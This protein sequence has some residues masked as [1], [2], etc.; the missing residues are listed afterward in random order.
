MLRPENMAEGAPESGSKISTTPLGVPE[1]AQEVA[2]ATWGGENPLKSLTGQLGGS[3]GGLTPDQQERLREVQERGRFS[4]SG[5]PVATEAGGLPGGGGRPPVAEG[6][7]EPESH[8]EWL[9]SP[10]RGR[11]LVEEFLRYRLTMS[12]EVRY[13]T[14]NGPRF[15]WICDEI[16]KYVDGISETRND[17]DEFGPYQAFPRPPERKLIINEAG[18]KVLE[19][20]RPPEFLPK[21]QELER[22]DK[23][24]EELH[25]QY[26]LEGA[27]QLEQPTETH[28]RDEALATENGK[29][30]FA[31]SFWDRYTKIDRI[32]SDDESENYPKTPDELDALL[33]EASTAIKQVDVYVRQ[34][35]N[36]GLLEEVEVVLNSLYQRI[37]QPGISL[38]HVRAYLRDGKV[39]AIDAA[40]AEFKEKSLENHNLAVF[41]GIGK[42][43]VELAL[44]T[45]ERSVRGM[46]QP[47]KERGE[48][49]WLTPSAEQA[50]KGKKETYWTTGSWPKYYQVTAETEEQFLVAKDTFFQMIRTA[51]LGKS[52]DAV[53][54]HVQNFIEAFKGAG[55]R[56]V[57]ERNISNEFLLEN[58]LELEALLFV[59]V[60]NYS[61]E[62]YNHKQRYDAMMA[63]SKDEGP[64]R[65]VGIY[66]SGKGGAAS[67]GEIFDMEA[68]MDIY[69]NPVGE[70]GELTITSGHFLQ[71]MIQEIVIERGMGIAL[72][73]Y[74]P[75]EPYLNSDDLKA[76]IYAAKELERINSDLQEY[77]RGIRD[78]NL[79]LDAG[80]Q[81]VKL[82]QGVIELKNGRV[83][84][85]RGCTAEWLLSDRDQTRL[86][87]F[88]S[89]LK[90][91]GLTKSHEEFRALYEGFDKGDTH[92]KNYRS[93][94]KAQKEDKDKPK[95]Q[96][97]FLFEDLPESIR[98]SIDLGRIQIEVQ[99][100]RQKIIKGEV[101]PERGKR[102]ADL[103]ADPRDRDIYKEAFNEAAA[104]FDVAFQMQGVLG[105]KGRRGRGFLYVDRNKHIRFYFEVWDSLR[106]QGKDIDKTQE[107]EDLLA[108]FSEDQKE[109]FKIGRMLSLM[110]DK[111][112]P[113]TFT[114]AERRFYDNLSPENKQDFVDNLP[115]YQAENFVQWGVFWTKMK[116]ADDAV[117]WDE[118]GGWKTWSDPIALR[119][120]K[121]N[122]DAKKEELANFKAKYRK[123]KAEE[124]R[125]RLI[126]QLRTKGYEAQLTSDELGPDR[127]P[128][129]MTYKRPLGAMDSSRINPVTCWLKPFKN[130]EVVGY[131]KTGQEIRLSFDEN[132]ESQGLEFDDQGKVL[133]YD[134]PG[135]DDRKRILYDSINVNTRARLHAGSGVFVEEVAATFGFAALSDDFRNRYT[136]HTY[137]YYQGNNRHTILTD[138]IFKAARRI[139]DGISRP[140]DEDILAT[141]L[142]VVDPTLCRV[143][144]LPDRQANREVKLIAA[145]VLESFQG[146]QRTRHALHRAFLPEDGFEGRLGGAGY[147]NEDWAGYDRFTM[148]FEELVAQ[149]PLRF[150]RRSK[151]WIANVPMEH[152]AAGPRWGVHG[153]G[154][155]VKAMADEIKYITH[156]GIV[157]QFGLTK[158]FEVLYKSVE[159][160]NK[161]VGYTDPQTGKHVF[162]VMEKPTDNNE[163]MH[164]YTKD[165]MDHKILS[166]PTF[167]I[168]FMYDLLK[169]VGRLQELMQVMRVVDTNNDNSAG[170]LDLE[171]VDTFLEDGRFNPELETNQEI[172]LKNGTARNRQHAFLF[173]EGNWEGFWKW[174]SDRRPGR[175]G[176]VYKGERYWN[177]FFHREYKK[178]DGDVAKDVEPIKV[179]ATDKVI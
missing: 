44:R 86:G 150:A 58:R 47:L 79:Q 70:R 120:R 31:K 9:I 52:P 50:S 165:S 160:Y 158:I 2:S 136:D 81:E 36:N 156:Q 121:Q 59:F 18:E 108:S 157:G 65:W 4:T 117:I 139:R 37:T 6:P 90:R 11:W 113:V 89:N 168:P 102:A 93:Y 154:G 141:A 145:A 111:K 148:G 21:P 78:N 83:K 147:R 34:A 38:E 138:K 8:K 3:P 20:F 135:G 155:A 28:F 15:K 72:K 61:N 69:M 118:R 114:D 88:K 56:Q 101:T 49:E 30:I 146:K 16:D 57:Q 40:Q 51:G 73:D 109:S 97:R 82:K 128:K 76:K 24:V 68:L 176:D 46:P 62:V 71:D 151:A 80:L 63:M 87:A 29:T 162:G 92:I 177:E 112:R 85:R 5:E 137:W 48:G 171:E 77:R 7:R 45:M 67:F 91:L 106:L 53:Y 127:Q 175:G 105:E 123:A 152:D 43:Y 26:M 95:D 25:K 140:E 107:Y 161:L 1:S 166:D 19:K 179:W 27:E 167:S 54:E 173:G 98:R 170:A 144:K 99:E 17:R 134:K 66:R 116:Y 178:F 35:K 94:E 122:K 74:D 12:Y 115:V 39:E 174:L 149:Q 153:V 33:E 119:I 164:K 22:L 41:A 133:I 172:T 129:I 169:C 142:L 131:N 163:I 110:R 124:T 125:D 60:G 132:G 143:M 23:V 130:G 64:A 100:I 14:E 104:N 42:A 159:M 13:N 55:G 126:E 84:I 75:R 32:L 103:L 10:E 96:R